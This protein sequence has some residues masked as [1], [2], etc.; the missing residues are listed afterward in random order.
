VVR[1][2]LTPGTEILLF[3]HA[4]FA[5]DNELAFELQFLDG[6]INGVNSDT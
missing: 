1:E 2:E 5:L 4:G 3:S 6:R